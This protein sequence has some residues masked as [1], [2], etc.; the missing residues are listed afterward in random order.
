MPA[1]KKQCP[2]VHK[3]TITFHSSSQL[4]SCEGTFS[5]IEQS[6]AWF[7][8]STAGNHPNHIIFGNI[9]EKNVDHVS[10]LSF[11]KE[12]SEKKKKAQ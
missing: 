11:A 3:M 8:A 4:A 1:T 2:K 5:A 12:F 9:Q 6:K 10:I 7:M